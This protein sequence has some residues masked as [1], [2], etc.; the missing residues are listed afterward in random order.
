MDAYPDR[1]CTALWRFRSQQG[2]ST[3]LQAD[4]PRVLRVHLN[5]K[6]VLRAGGGCRA[7]A[8]VADRNL[9]AEGT[10]G[11]AAGHNV[12][13]GAI[14]G[15]DAEGRGAIAPADDHAEIDGRIAGV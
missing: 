9:D 6:V 12:C 2:S 11:V 13:A 14:A 10:I 5:A 3:L 8:I 15:D 4:M 7:G 1:R